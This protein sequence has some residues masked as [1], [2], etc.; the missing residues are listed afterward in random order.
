MEEKECLFPYETLLSYKIKYTI[1][2]LFQ[3]H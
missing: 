2:V 1:F 3:A